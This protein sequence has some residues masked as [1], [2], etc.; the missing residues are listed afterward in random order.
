L[1]AVLVVARH[2]VG[3]VH[4]VV[5]IYVVT[6]AVLSLHAAVVAVLLVPVA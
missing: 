1:T 5:A 4:V 6:A 3:V 2:V